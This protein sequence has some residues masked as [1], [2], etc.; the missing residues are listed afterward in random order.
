M[1]EP[2][3]SRIL[4]PWRWFV[5][6]RTLAVVL[7]ARYDALGWAPLGGGFR[8]VVQIL[9][10]QV[11]LG[12]RAATEAP[13]ASLRRVARKLGFKPAETTAMMTGAAVDRAAAILARRS[14]LAVGAWCTAGLSNALRVGDRATAGDSAPGTINLIVAIDRPMSRPALVEAVQIAVEARTAAMLDARVTSVCSARPATGTGTD[15]VVV[16]AASASVEFPAP[17][18]YCGMHTVAGELLGRAVY[19]SVTRAIARA[20]RNPPQ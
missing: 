20:I 7:P 5:C 4:G 9:N 15:C 16:A 1:N 10:H 13:A 11:S 6:D 19:A 8:R 18:I 3:A 12:D 2:R 14:K 17:L